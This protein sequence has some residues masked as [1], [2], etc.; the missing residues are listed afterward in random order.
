MILPSRQDI[1]VYDSLDERCACEHFLG[2]SLDEAEALFRENWLYYQEDLLFMG[3]GAFRFYVQAAIRYIQ[4]EA[5]TGDSSEV[6]CFAMI[7]ESRLEHESAELVPIADRLASI[8]GYILEQRERFDFTSET[9]DAHPG[10]VQTFQ[11]TLLELQ[12]R[13][14]SLSHDRAT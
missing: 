9:L 10:R 11:Q 3:I 4:S 8:C 1:N 13:F 5:A 14:K 7:L 2:K 12:K 6:S